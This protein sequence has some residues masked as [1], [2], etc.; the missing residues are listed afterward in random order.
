MAIS[1]LFT[2]FDGVSYFLVMHSAQFFNTA[3][4]IIFI[5]II[6]EIIF[7]T[8]KEYKEDIT[9]TRQHFS[10]ALNIL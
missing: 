2:Y 8:C 10:T 9:Y 1:P 7:T 4:S 5:N 6:F 3:L